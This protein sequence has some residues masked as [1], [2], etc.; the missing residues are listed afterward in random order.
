MR[1]PAA[2]PEGVDTPTPA[3][4]RPKRAPAKKRPAARAAK[5]KAPHV[6]VRPP[7]PRWIVAARIGAAAIAIAAAVFLLVGGGGDRP[8]EIRAG[9]ATP[10]TADELAEFARSFSND[11]YWAGA[12]AS[13][14]L[15]LT[16][17]QAATF[18]RYGPDAPGGDGSSLTVATYP[19][20]DA[21]ATA[22]RRARTEG[23]S[24]RRT[25]DGGIAVW[26]R[27]RPTS[28]YLAW[29]GTPSLVEVYAPTAAE[30]RS[31]ALS[32]RVRPVR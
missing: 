18:V 24:S 17:S 1:K 26:S 8:A 12:L 31:I 27:S 15:E 20:G 7:A 9:T 29:R 30:A 32:G 10:V 23:M 11:V 21:Y 16:A 5:P 22:T 3:K 28:V 2:E 6:P 13:R 4:P 19:L 14:P 25:A